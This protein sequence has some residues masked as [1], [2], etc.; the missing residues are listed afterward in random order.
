MAPRDKACASSAGSSV[1]CGGETKEALLRLVRDYSIV[2]FTFFFIHFSYKS[3]SDTTSNI[4]LL[5][6]A[7]FYSFAGASHDAIQR[8]SK[9]HYQ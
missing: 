8:D 1:Q 9:D 7:H 2:L 4:Y 3:S 5:N 6:A